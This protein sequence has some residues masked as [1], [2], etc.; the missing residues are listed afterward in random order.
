VEDGLPLFFF[1]ERREKGKIPENGSFSSIF[2][3]HSIFSPKKRLERE[4]EVR[5]EG[6]KRGKK[7]GHVNFSFT[8]LAYL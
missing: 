6:K 4:K 8:F 5:G 7:R 3:Y 2:H 1:L